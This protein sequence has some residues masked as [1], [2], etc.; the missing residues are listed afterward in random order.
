MEVEVFTVVSEEQQ[1]KTI[2]EI[3]PLHP[4]CKWYSPS[5]SIIDRK[6]LFVNLNNCNINFNY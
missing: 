1:E 5:S 2:N 4:M 6:N 3:H